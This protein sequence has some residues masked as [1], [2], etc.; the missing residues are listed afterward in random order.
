MTKKQE[1]H[2]YVNILRVALILSV[3]LI[4]KDQF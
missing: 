4:E 3:S 1:L 2:I